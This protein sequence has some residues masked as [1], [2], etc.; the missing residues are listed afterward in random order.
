MVSQYQPSDTYK[1]TKWQDICN[2]TIHKVI[3]TNKEGVWYLSHKESMKK[4]SWTKK[5]DDRGS[6]YSIYFVWTPLY[7]LETDRW[8]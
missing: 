4:E 7:Y 1:Q 2:W 5:W 6:S 8:C 3:K